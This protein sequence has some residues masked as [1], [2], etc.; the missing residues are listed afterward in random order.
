MPLTGK[1]NYTTPVW[2]IGFIILSQIIFAVVLIKASI[3]VKSL[4]DD[5]FSVWDI[6]G[7]Y[8][9]TQGVYMLILLAEAITYWKIRNSVVRK[10][11]VWAHVGGLLFSF[12]FLPIF[13]GIAITLIS[14]NNSSGDVRKN[15]ETLYQIRTILFWSILVIA[16][17]FFTLLLIDVFKKSRQQLGPPAPDSPDILNDYA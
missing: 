4:Q 3:R 15:V 5:G 6:Y 9:I 7:P 14:G 10:D 17:I 16:H 1:K 8:L 2:W 12:F 11:F 13:Y